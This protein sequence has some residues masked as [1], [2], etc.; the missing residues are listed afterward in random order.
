MT[1]P[2]LTPHQSQY[3]AWL[4]TRRAAGDTVESLASTLVDSQVDLNPHQVDA[5]L[6]ACRNPLSRG[7]ILADEVGLGKTIEA[8]LVISQRWAE[9][10]RKIL[11]IVPANL[12]KQWHQELQDKFTLQGLILEAKNYNALRKQGLQNPFQSASGPVICSYQF[13]KAKAQDVKDITWDLVVLDEA[14]RLRNVYKTSN[15]IAKTLKDA[16]ADVSSKVLLTATPLQNS[17]LELY[18]LVSIID[19]RVFG[20]LDSFRTQFTT[21][22]REQAFADLRHRL[23]AVSKRTLRRQVQPYVSYTARKAIVQEFTPSSEEQEL[24]R[25]VA[26]YLR[27]PNL[28]ALPEGQRKLISLV[29]WKLLAS[30]SHAIAG[31]LETMA[32]R[33]QS[34]LDQAPVIDLTEELD[35]DYEALDELADES[36]DDESEKEGLMSVALSVEERDAFSAEIGELQQFKHLATNIRDDAKGNALLTALDKAFAELERLGAAKKAIIFTE[37]RRTQD[38]LL[39]L[40]SSTPYGDGIV[41]FNGTNSDTGAK[42]TYMDWLKR[43]EGTDRITGS[44]TADTRA[45][46]VEHFKERGKVMIATEAGAEGINLQFCS[47]VINYDLPWNPQRIEQRI[48]R[49]HR[50]GQKHDVVVVNFVDRS[51]EADARV[52]ELL[53]QKFRLFEGVFGASDEVLGAIGSGVDFERRIADIYQNCRNPDQIKSSFE[54]LQLDLSGE[55][56][57]A[58]VRTRQVLLE[59]FDEQVQEKL[60]ISDED[61]KNA[62]SRFERMLMELS[63]AELYEFASFDDD[64]F[65]LHNLPDGISSSGI[66]LGRYELPRRTGEAHLYRIGHPLALWIAEQAKGRTLEGARLTFDYEAY[67]KKIATLEPYRGKTGWLTVKLLSVAA[68]G[69]KEEHLLVAASTAGGE[70]LAEEDPEKL[71]RLPA[72]HRAAGLFYSGDTLLADAETRKTELLRQINERNL[73]YF[74][75]EVQK[76]DAWADDL[77]FGLEQQIKEID[78][79][80]KEVRGTAA[81]APTLEEKLSWQKKQRDLEARRSKLRRDLFIRQDEVEEQRNKLIGELEDQ[82]KQRVEEKTLFTVEWELK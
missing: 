20:D 4:L 71:L 38:Y 60:R 78:R 5:A 3:F 63:R 21:Q 72:T 30:S 32:M 77:K 37:S 82:L 57:E 39:R 11:I 22:S 17:L 24:S 41:L 52:Y 27:R 61:S 35:E 76:L 48:G 14:H 43:H 66:S 73:G 56:N 80:I 40:L 33:L 70:A 28:K 51:N 42:A 58:M 64:G 13:A 10:R 12:R 25:L 6:F 9:R 46:L 65:S 18:G 62:R 81:T 59:N 36:G 68:L 79:Q 53:A 16:L 75:Q 55:I 8:G 34:V 45:A 49:C 2:I 69:D 67:G 74:E 7:V 26:E 50:Y 1:P 19:D 15:V 29:L 23:A 44:K 31:A 54:Q 47:L